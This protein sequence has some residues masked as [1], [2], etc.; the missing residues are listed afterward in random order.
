M[1]MIL[2]LGGLLI[3]TLFGLSNVLDKVEDIQ[4]DSEKTAI[5]LGALILVGVGALLVY[6]LVIK[7][8]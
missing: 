3:S 8:G 7:K 2:A 4:N 5:N 1:P 6:K